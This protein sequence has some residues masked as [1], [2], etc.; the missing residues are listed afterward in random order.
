MSHSTPRLLAWLGWFWLACSLPVQAQPVPASEKP[1]AS[2][3]PVTATVVALDG[4]QLVIDLGRRQVRQGAVLTLYRNIEVSHPTSGARLRDRF[5]NGSVRVMQVGDALS[6]VKA[7]SAP[8]RPPI[9]GDTAEAEAATIE[10]RSCEQCEAQSALQRS[11]LEVFG[12]T[13]GKPPEERVGIFKAYLRQSPSSPFRGWLEYEIAYFSSGRFLA[14]MA[15][16]AKSSFD[17]AVQGLV[18]VGSLAHA[19]AGLPVEFGVY[20]PPE[21]QVRSISVLLRRSDDE[22]DYTRRT[23]LL[24]ERGQGRLRVPTELVQAPGFSYFVEAQ[25]ADNRTL[26]VLASASKPE[27]CTVEAVPLARVEHDRSRV[28]AVSE[29]VSFDGLSGRDYYYLFE[30]DFLLRTS[31]RVLEG[32]RVG[33]GEYRGKG[34]TVDDLDVR[35]LAPRPAAF[36]YGYLEAIFA[37]HELFA[38]IPRVEVGLGRPSDQSS[39]HSRVRPGGQL[40]VRIGRARGTNLTVGGESA[41]EIGQRA[42]VGLSLGLLEKVPLAF[43]VHVT[44][45]PVNTNQLGV[46]AVVDVGYRPS[47]VFALSARASYQGRT[48]D[49][50]GP[51][52]GL[53]ATFGW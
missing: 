13:L 41:P 20:V 37:L 50:A 35:H 11:V 9:V 30:G 19:Q 23:V 33:Y 42:F 21:V 44:D 32:V 43:E 31:M 16:Q 2:E 1:S 10:P 4:D 26:G 25:L 8:P 53:A 52:L 47:E 46:R 6:I 49:H 18:K 28:R 48:I 15:R 12:R 51:G 3:K 5:P 29:Y 39:T 17:T 27:R 38:V 24:D 22:G 14:S 7:E 40:R 45:Q 34:G 36:T